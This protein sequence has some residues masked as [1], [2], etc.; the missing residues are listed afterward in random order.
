MGTYLFQQRMEDLY[1]MSKDCVLQAPTGAGKTRA[2]L[3]PALL[4]FESGELLHYPQRIVF[5]TPM[6]TLTM[7]HYENVIKAAAIKGW[8]RDYSIG[9]Q[10]GDLPDDPRF[11]KRIVFVTVDQLL[12]SFLNVPY[13]LPR[14]QDNLNAGAFIGSY[15]VFDE[16]HLYPQQQMMLSVLAMLVMLKDVSR[17]T[18]MSATFSHR[19]LD[20]VGKVLGAEVV[21]EDPQTPVETSLFHDVSSV[22]TQ[23]RTWYTE[24]GL[25]DGEAVARL[26]QGRTLC[27]CNTVLSAQQLYTAVR[28]RLPHVECHM[29]HARF[30]RQDRADKEEFIRQKFEQS[31]SPTILI[32]TQVVEVGLDISCDV[33]L[34]ECAPAASLIQRAGRCARRDNEW[35]RVHVFLPLDEKGRVSYAPYGDVRGEDGQQEIFDRTWEALSSSDYNGMVLRFREEQALINHTHGPADEAFVYK[36]EQRV[37]DRIDK[38]TRCIATREDGLIAS[39]IREQISVPV[40]VQGEPNRDDVLTQKPHQRQSFGL[41]RGLLYHAFKTLEENNSTAPFFLMGCTG[42]DENPDNQKS[43]DGMSLPHYK[44]YPLRTA[45]EVYRGGYLWFT[46]HPEAA[47][48]DADTGLQLAVSGNPAIE[49]PLIER[50]GHER[51]RF[52]YIADTYQEHIRGL[53]LAY[54]KPDDAQERRPL[55]DEFLYPLQRLCLKLN[56]PPDVGERMLRLVLALHDI[57]KLN[58]PWQD[59]AEAW[60]YFYREQGF[61]PQRLPEDGALAHTDIDYGDTRQ[62]SM[63]QAFKHAPRGTHAVESAQAAL[64]ILKDAAGEDTFWLTVAAAAIMRHHTPGAERCDAFELIP[65]GVIEVINGLRECGFSDDETE[66]WS[67]LL[68]TNFDYSSPRLA[69]LA[70]RVEP[71]RQDWDTGLMYLLFVRVLRLADQRSGDFLRR[72]QI[73]Q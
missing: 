59:W 69:K 19:F 54:T 73:D 14:R 67:A 71:D 63:I 72:Y 5:A 38:I 55:R 16:F 12:A 68:Q 65:N 34:T 53:Y 2:A 42:Q 57:G 61:Q 50:V 41:S 40:Y 25:L 20:V 6:R 33:L 56:K 29:L 26:A 51:G 9:I 58:R 70:R 48:Y 36:L 23:Q 37:D 7:S 28:E 49:S 30:Y 8:K 35:G 13:G 66:R 46:I 18:L 1:K 52:R 17:F 60:Q 43:D 10:T 11:E 45:D 27:V 4:G 21:A 22:Q 64:E 24:D 39:L 31:E 3:Q 62:K 44:W 32:A 47:T 15:L